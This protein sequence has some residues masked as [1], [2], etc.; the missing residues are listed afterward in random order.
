[1]YAFN[2]DSRHTLLSSLLLKFNFV[3][4]FDLVNTTGRVNEDVCARIRRLNEAEAFCFIK[5]FNCA[6]HVGL[7]KI[8]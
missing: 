7:F 4:L 2:V 1:M 5:E 3:V 6:L 8:G